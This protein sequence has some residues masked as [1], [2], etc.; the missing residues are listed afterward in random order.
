MPSYSQKPILTTSDEEYTILLE[1]AEE[2]EKQKIDKT[3]R[4]KVGSPSVIVLRNHLLQ[5]KLN[6]SIN[7]NVIIEGSKIKN[8]LL[9][10]KNGVEPNQEAFSRDDVKMAIEVKNNG[11]A[12]KILDNG[13][14]EDPN[15]VVRFKFNEL[16]ALTFVKNFAV[17]VLSETLLPP[18]S[19]FK[20]R[21]REDAIGKK[22]C[23]VFTLIARQNYPSGGLYIKSNLAEMLQNAQMKPTGEFQQLLNYLQNL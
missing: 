4:E 7:S 6:F 17:V 16:E 12:A 20:W 23:K 2:F 19:P 11:I 10:L 18:R 15:K 1:V 3:A 13:K 21:F 14:L 5:R 9:L 8:D 22:N